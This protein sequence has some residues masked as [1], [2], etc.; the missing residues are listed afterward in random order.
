LQGRS[1]TL[2]IHPIVLVSQTIY[3]RLQCHPFISAT[4]HA[5]MPTP[6]TLDHALLSELVSAGAVCAVHVAARPGGWAVMISCETK[7]YMLVATRTHQVRL[8]KKMETLIAYLKGMGMTHFDID[9][10]D[11]DP[12]SVKTY[13]RPD[14]SE[15][16]KQAHQAA[17][18]DD[19]FRAQV[20]EAL[21]EADNPDTAWL[22]NDQVK[23]EFAKK[24]AALLDRIQKDR[25]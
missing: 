9:I 23:A 5:A 2:A 16:L 8:F 3:Y 17:A 25:E 10:T 19:W 24:R 6:E 13:S 22:T 12:A 7:Q 20:Q 18:Y 14:R 15:A 21:Q 4:R 1:L 11:Y